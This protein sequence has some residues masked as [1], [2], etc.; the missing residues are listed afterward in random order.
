MQELHDDRRRDVRHDAEHEDRELRERST[1]EQ[2]Q[3]AHDPIG[4]RRLLEHFELLDVDTGNRNVSAE[5]IQRNHEQR[6]QGSCCA[7][8]GA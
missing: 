6:E 7:A 3:E 5:A 1:G 8:R 4:A 2:V